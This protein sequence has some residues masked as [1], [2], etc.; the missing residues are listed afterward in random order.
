MFEIS[1]ARCGEFPSAPCQLKFAGSQASENG[2]VI[3][4]IRRLLGRLVCC[5]RPVR[6][7]LIPP[8]TQRRKRATRSL[9]QASSHGMV[10]D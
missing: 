5:M 10:P 4:D 9:G 7:Y 6:H 1:S 3:S 8:S 2:R